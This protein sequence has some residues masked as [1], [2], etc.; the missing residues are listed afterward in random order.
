MRFNKLT[1][2]L[3]VGAVALTGGFEGYRQVAYQDSGGVWTACYGETLGI[4]Q[5]DYFTKAECD[6]MFGQSLQK[7][8]TP[9]EDI[10]QQLPANVHLASLDMAYNIGTGAFQRS[11][12]YQYLRAGQYPQACMEMPR[13]RYVTIDGKPRDCRIAKWDCRGIVTRREIVS[14]LCL[15]QLSIN[16]A[17]ARLGQLPLDKEIIERIKA[18]ADTQ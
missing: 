16:D 5:G 3:L 11:T 18:D 1:K 10:P 4:E 13:W 2:A 7:H 14:Q 15:G 17:L 8:N 9:L 6:E 12:L